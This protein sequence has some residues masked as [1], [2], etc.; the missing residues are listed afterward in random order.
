MPRDERDRA[1]DAPL[2]ERRAEHA[3]EP[4]GERGVV[5]RGKA[6]AAADAGASN[7]EFIVWI[8]TGSKRRF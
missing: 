5:R 7:A 1:D 3:V 4:C 2:A 8:L 6:A